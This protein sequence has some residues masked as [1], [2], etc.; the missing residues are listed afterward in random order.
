MY[1]WSWRCVELRMVYNESKTK[2]SK[3][4]SIKSEVPEWYLKC[5]ATR[6]RNLDNQ[7]RCYDKLFKRRSS[8]LWVLK[9]K[10]SK[11]LWLVNGN[12]TSPL[13]VDSK[14]QKITSMLFFMFDSETDQ[15]YIDRGTTALGELRKY[16]SY[17][18][19][20]VTGKRCQSMLQSFP[21][22]SV[23]INLWEHSIFPTDCRLQI[24]YRLMSVN[25]L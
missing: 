22:W 3:L 2:R 17:S 12:K 10:L 20:T 5:L 9:M 7:E 21:F 24:K 14:A 25:S 19:V 6:V 18:L 23:L 1:T 15:R 4:V 16:C 8:G 11:F 13:Y